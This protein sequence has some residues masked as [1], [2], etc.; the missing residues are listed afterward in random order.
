MIRN[1]LTPA[2]TIENRFANEQACSPA[3][4]NAGTSLRENGVMP[5]DPADASLPRGSRLGVYE[6]IG[7][8]GAG[9]MGLVVRAVDTRLGRTVA[10]KVLY[11]DAARDER[12]LRRLVG[13]ARAA[14][15]LNHPNIL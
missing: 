14:S 8:L 7:P 10:I 15:A 9:G 4:P 3:G 12:R 1:R 5:V 13:E 6:I 2:V 11:A